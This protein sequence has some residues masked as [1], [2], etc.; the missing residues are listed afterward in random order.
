MRMDCLKIEKCACFKF[1]SCQHLRGSD[2]RHHEHTWCFEKSASQNSATPW[3]YLWVQG[4]LW[5]FLFWLL[6]HLV[7]LKPCCTFP[8]GRWN[9]RNDWNTSKLREWTRT[10][11]WKADPGGVWGVHWSF[12]FPSL[13]FTT[14][15]RNHDSYH[16]PEILRPRALSKEIIISS[17]CAGSPMKDGKT[18]QWGQA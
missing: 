18:S 13:L 1:T 3:P 15:R 17:E 7:K 16:F 6:L 14:N 8:K 5:L 2:Q 9:Y 4:L 10:T 12:Q 11:Q